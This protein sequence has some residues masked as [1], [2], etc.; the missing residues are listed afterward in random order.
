MSREICQER[1]LRESGIVS[2]CV[3]CSAQDGCSDAVALQLVLLSKK[4]EDGRVQLM[5]RCDRFQPFSGS[6]SRGERNLAPVLE[7]AGVANLCETCP[8]EEKHGCAHRRQLDEII[9]LADHAGR[10]IEPIIVAC[11]TVNVRADATDCKKLWQ[12]SEPDR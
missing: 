11:T 10:S 6:F 12:I 7:A 8:S 2:R 5:R 1:K 4:P 3:D 9:G